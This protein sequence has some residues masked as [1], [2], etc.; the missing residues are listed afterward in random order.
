MLN[1]QKMPARSPA[2]RRF[3]RWSRVA[4]CF[5][6]KR[7]SETGKSAP[8]EAT[9]AGSTPRARPRPEENRRSRPAAPAIR[10]PR[11]VR[12]SKNHAATRDHLGKGPQARTISLGERPPETS[13]RE[14]HPTGDVSR[15]PWRDRPSPSRTP[16]QNQPCE[17]GVTAFPQLS[18]GAAREAR[19]A[20]LE[21][22]ASGGAPA[23]RVRTSRKRRRRFRASSGLSERLGTPRG[24]RR[25]PKQKTQEVRRSR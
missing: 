2:A 20:P 22:G 1:C 11:K 8:R 16:L 6:E 5:F 12:F 21:P 9:G 15:N 4:A 3:G 18:Q 19:P 13:R 23:K 25:C 14:R 7:T 24:P 10:A 17:A